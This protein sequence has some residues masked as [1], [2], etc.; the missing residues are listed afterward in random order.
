VD[1]PRIASEMR[2][3][4]PVDLGSIQNG[5]ALLPDVVIETSQDLQIGGRAFRVNLALDAAARGDIWML[6]RTRGVLALAIS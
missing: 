1:D 2:E 4:V 3:D 5:A 6:D